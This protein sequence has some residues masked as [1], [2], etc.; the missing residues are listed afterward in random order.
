MGN[1]GFTHLFWMYF[2][3]LI[4]QTIPQE[5]PTLEQIA[6][7]Q[8]LYILEQYCHYYRLREERQKNRKSALVLLNAAFS[9]PPYLYTKKDVFEFTDNKGT[10]LLKCYSTKDLEAFLTAK[11][12]GGNVNELPE[13]LSCWGPSGEQCVVRKDRVLVYG[14]Q[15]VIDARVLVKDAITKRWLNMLKQYRKEASMQNERDFDALVLHCVK[16]SK[17]HLSM[18]TSGLSRYDLTLIENALPATETIPRSLR[19]INDGKMMPLKE[20]L[21]LNREKLLQGCYDN[22]SVLYSLPIYFKFMAFVTGLGKKKKDNETVNKPSDTSSEKSLAALKDELIPKRYTL[23][24]YLANVHG[25][26]NKLLDNQA[27]QKLF[28]DVNGL[29]RT[30]LGSSK[31]KRLHINTEAFEQMA[32]DIIAQAPVLQRSIREEGALRLYMKLYMIKLMESKSR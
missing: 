30:Y 23:D 6:L 13:L 4:K 29:V 1:G 20:L 2:C 19:L 15:I 3:T 25:K 7:K 26:W 11:T 9:K 16:E 21:L 10:P 12:S 24:S 8:A 32:E 5:D 17:P 18:L 14:M 27:R 28:D 22:L 31:G